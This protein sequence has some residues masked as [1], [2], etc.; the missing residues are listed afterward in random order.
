M[1]RM[2]LTVK[3]AAEHIGV[4]PQTLRYWDKKGYLKPAL[5]T[6]GGQRRYTLDQLEKFLAGITEED[7]KEKK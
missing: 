3:Q 5:R 7:R 4:H 6:P 2:H 1:V